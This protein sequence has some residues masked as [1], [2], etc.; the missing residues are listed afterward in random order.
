MDFYYAT[1]QQVSCDTNYEKHDSY[2]CGKAVVARE[3]WK[4]ENKKVR[5]NEKAQLQELI[6]R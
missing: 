4:N 6:V 5:C 1:R 3:A 2:Q